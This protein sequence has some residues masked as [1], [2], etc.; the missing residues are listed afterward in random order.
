LFSLLV[1]TFLS[2]VSYFLCIF[3]LFRFSFFFISCVFYFF[4]MFFF[5]KL[6]N[7]SFFLEYFFCFFII[8]FVLGLKVTC[9]ISV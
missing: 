9:F 1:G 6:C 3:L 4:L 2:L 8:F 5:C 7:F